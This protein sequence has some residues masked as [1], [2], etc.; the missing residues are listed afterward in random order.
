MVA[1]S[2]AVSHQLSPAAARGCIRATSYKAPAA[3]GR[4]A[5]MFELRG[6]FAWPRTSINNG[7][8]I[9]EL[10]QDGFDKCFRD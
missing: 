1:S 3:G 6:V 2:A 5:A 7:I 10:L 9:K 4:V 8:A